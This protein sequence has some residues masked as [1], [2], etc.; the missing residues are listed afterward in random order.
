MA[1]LEEDIAGEVV[2]E[3]GTWEESNENTSFGS[4]LHWA[5]GGRKHGYFPSYFHRL[6]LSTIEQ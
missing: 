6:L 1:G 4:L 2:D 3:S 5:D